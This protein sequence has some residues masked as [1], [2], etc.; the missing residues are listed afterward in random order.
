[1]KKSTSWGSILISDLRNG[2]YLGDLLVEPTKGQISGQ[3]GSVN[4]PPKS[5]EVL[6]FLAE[7]SGELLT[8][9]ELIEVEKVGKLDPHADVTP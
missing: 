1:L 5:M 6:L 2:F 3:T 9:D 8:Q 4:L 7:R